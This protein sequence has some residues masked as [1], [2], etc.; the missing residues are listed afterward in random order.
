MPREQ[1]PSLTI[2]LLPRTKMV[3]ARVLAHSSMTSIRSRVVPKDTSRTTPAFP[4][5]AADRS[6]KRGTIRPSV[7]IAISWGGDW[8]TSTSRR[9]QRTHLDLR[10]TNPSHSRE[11]ILHKQMVRLVVESPLADDQ[12]STGVLNS[13]DHI[14]K[15]LLF[16]LP[17]LVVL[18]Y[19]GD[20]ELVLRLRAGRLKRASENGEFG[21]LDPARHLGVGHVLVQEHTLDE[22]CIIERTTNFA[23]DLDQ[24]EGDVFALHIRYLEHCID[25]D[26]GEFFMCFRYAVVRSMNKSD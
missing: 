24:V 12:I 17:E 13:L 8:T 10:S 14:R 26:L 2:L 5:F 6:S 11:L 20:I 22:G 18:F 25:G 23:I 19:A 15:L 16:V 1:G 21:V 4:S 9:E 3:T 7:A